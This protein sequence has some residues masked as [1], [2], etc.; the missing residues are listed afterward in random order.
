MGDEENKE[1]EN[2]ILAK[3]LIASVLKEKEYE[4][5]KEFKGEELL[6]IEYEK[7]MPFAKVDGKA[8]VIIHGDYVNL[9]DGT[10]IVHIAP[11]YGEDDSLVSKWNNIC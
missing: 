6:G 1:Y 11:A 8:F 9:E 4:I 7:L 5:I 3:G 10:G 2:Y